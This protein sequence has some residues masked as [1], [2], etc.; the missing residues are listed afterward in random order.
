MNFKKLSK[1]IFEEIKPKL[2]NN[3]GLYI[4]ARE[5]AKFE[6]WLKVELCNILSKYFKEVAPERKRIDVTFNNWAIELKTVT[7]LKKSTG[8][9]FKLRSK[10]I[11]RILDDIRKLESFE[12]SNKS[13]LFVVFP[14]N[15]SNKDW[16][17]QLKIIRTYLK[18]IKHYLP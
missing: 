13:I 8:K 14:I 16:K 7:T 3:Q 12:Y 5:K 11:P 2:E 10:D 4:F 9:K 18:K 15:H 6:G 1:L 17:T